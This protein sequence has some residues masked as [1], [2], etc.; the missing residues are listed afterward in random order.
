MIYHLHETDGMEIPRQLMRKNIANAND[1]HTY[2]SQNLSTCFDKQT[3]LEFI[4]SISS[5]FA[6]RSTLA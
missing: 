5:A 6:Q 1:R 2:L 3:I 4:A